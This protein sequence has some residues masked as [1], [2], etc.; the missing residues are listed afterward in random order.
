MKTNIIYVLLWICT[1]AFF[2]SAVAQDWKLTKQKNGISVYEASAGSSDFKSIKVVCTIEGSYDK[3]L[4]IVRDVSH[5]K[6]WVYH[7]KEASLLKTVSPNDFY[8]YTETTLPWP[9][10]NRDVVVHTT[11][12]RDGKDQFLKIRSSNH[13]GMVEKKPGKVRV[14]QSE[15]NWYVTA[16]TAKTISIVYTMEANPGG[17]IPAWLVNSFADKGPYE[18]F[19]KLEE[20]LKR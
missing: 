5:H 6:D 19:R 15:I 1:T 2:S 13:N 8:Y 14:E 10:T 16:P 11:I 4:K 18:S 9:A 20:L 3:L 12:T 7:N 17:S